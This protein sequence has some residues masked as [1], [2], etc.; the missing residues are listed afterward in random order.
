MKIELTT[1]NTIVCVSKLEVTSDDVDMNLKY[2]VLGQELTDEAYEDTGVNVINKGY[3]PS[4]SHSIKIEELKEILL[5]LEN[6]GCNYVSINY[7]C[8]H[9][10]YTF[11]GV[12]AHVATDE[13]I[14]EELEK[15]NDKE[16]KSAKNRLDFL[17]SKRDELLKNIDELENKKVK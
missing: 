8:D 1:K 3:F 14:K 13:D 17:N 11:V 12:D 2:D 9:T 15:E 6:T 16:L 10:D 7:N 5:K 4:D